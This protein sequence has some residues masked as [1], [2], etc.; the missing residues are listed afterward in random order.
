MHRYSKESLAHM[1]EPIWV[2]NDHIWL[3]DYI[4]KSHFLPRSIISNH[5]R[6]LISL[7]LNILENIWEK[8]VVSFN[9][10]LITGTFLCSPSICEGGCYVSELSF[11]KIWS[12]NE[13][14]FEKF[15]YG[16]ITITSCFIAYSVQSVCWWFEILKSLSPS[17]NDP[18]IILK[19]NFGIDWVIIF[20]KHIHFDFRKFHGITKFCSNTFLKNHRMESICLCKEDFSS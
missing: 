3:S 12:F 8:N 7:D 14:L 4:F 13:K 19:K 11:E 2:Q 18:F 20:M 17:I 6:F 15:S 16:H 10:F 9:T 5:L 1:W